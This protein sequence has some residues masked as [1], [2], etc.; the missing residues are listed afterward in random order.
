[1]GYRTVAIARGADKKAMAL[2]LGAHRYI[3]SAAQDPAKALQVLGGAS[4][5]VA[6]A[7]REPGE[8]RQSPRR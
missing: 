5:I 1:M 2:E 3:D 7:S 4:V 8:D 6:T